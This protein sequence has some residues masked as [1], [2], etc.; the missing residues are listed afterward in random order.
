MCKVN[1]FFFEIYNCSF[2]AEKALV[3]LITIFS[4]PEEE[5][6]SHSVIL[7]VIVLNKLAK[8]ARSF[9]SRII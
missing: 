5:D 8:L 1:P 2:F 7:S 3:E 6:S 4:E 9:I